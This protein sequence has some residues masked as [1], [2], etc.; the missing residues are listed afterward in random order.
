MRTSPTNI[1]LWMLSA[2]A[3]HDF[4]YLTVDQVV[5]KLTHT[6]KT[7]GKLERYEGHLLNWYDIQTLTPLEPRYVSTVDSGNLLGAL[8]SLE[9]GLDELIQTPVVDVKA[10]EGL[11]DTGDILKQVVQQKGI[12]GLNPHALD[13]LI[14]AW[15]APPDRIADALR[16]LRRME[17]SVRLSR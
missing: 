11:R 17:G 2:L 15:E 3:A 12:P 14:G 5:D 8:W 1:G 6:M 7:L 9:H 13:E 4:G 10:F 16:L